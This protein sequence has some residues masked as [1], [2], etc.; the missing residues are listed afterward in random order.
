M[1]QP[2]TSGGSAPGNNGHAVVPNV[3]GAPAAYHPALPNFPV[4][5]GLNSFA[6]SLNG[7]SQMPPQTPGLQAS[8][9][10]SFF[11][12]IPRPHSSGNSD[13]ERLER[14]KREILEGQNPIYKAVPQPNFLESIYL[15]RTLQAQN[16][17]PAHPEQVAIGENASTGPQSSAR[18]NGDVKTSDF[19]HSVLVNQ[20]RE[21]GDAAPVRTTPLQPA[22]S[23]VSSSSIVSSG[24]PDSTN[25]GRSSSMPQITSKSN[26][27]DQR[28]SYLSQIPTQDTPKFSPT[29]GNLDLPKRSL[30]Y[31][32]RQQASQPPSEKLSMLSMPENHAR[33]PMSSNTSVSSKDPPYDPKEGL[34]RPGD[35]AYGL[36]DRSRRVAD[37]R[38]SRAY[39]SRYVRNGDRDRER[40]RDKEL[41]GEHDRRFDYRSDDR[42]VSVEDYRVARVSSEV[43]IDRDQHS[44]KGLSH[45]DN[46]HLDNR[47]DADVNRS[48]PSVSGRSVRLADD[49]IP[50]PV[51]PGERLT[52]PSDDNSPIKHTT[53]NDKA[54][55]VSS[56][57]TSVNTD[58]SQS[59][60]D[61]NRLPRAS[62]SVSHARFPVDERS[63]PLDDRARLL[64]VDD[65]ERH[66]AGGDRSHQ[67]SQT[68][69]R[70][71][72]AS[73]L[74]ERIGGR[75]PPP[76][77]DRIGIRIPLEERITS[78]PL[79]RL[80]RPASALQERISDRP[81][82][83][84]RIGSRP[85]AADSRSLALGDIGDT[86]SVLTQSA[87]T[88]FRTVDEKTASLPLSATTNTRTL[89]QRVEDRHSRP[90]A[91]DVA[92]FQSRP[93]SYGIDTRA[94]TRDGP[95]PHPSASESFLKERY[96]GAPEQNLISAAAYR[97]DPDRHYTDTRRPDIEPAKHYERPI[98]RER[99]PTADHDHA[100]PNLETREWRERASYPPRT[101]VATRPE[102]YTGE[103]YTQ[104]PPS[105]SRDWAQNDRGYR[106]PEPAYDA[107]RPSPPIVDAE[108]DRY[109]DR[110][111][112]RRASLAPRSWDR[113][114]ALTHTRP[115]PEVYPP[116][117][118]VDV[119]RERYPP[120]DFREP[121]RVR[122]RSPSPHRRSAGDSLDEL[123]PTKRVREE[124][125]Y[126]DPPRPLPY[127]QPEH[128]AHSRAPSPPPSTAGSYYDTRAAYPPR[129]A[130]DAYSERERAPDLGYYERRPADMGPPRPSPY[131]GRAV[132]SRPDLDREGNRYSLPPP[133]TA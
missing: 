94:N 122:Q 106:L 4:F 100:K 59:A 12:Q 114:D 121:S 51:V 25:L 49:R 76:L 35:G 64:P 81:P 40:D 31:H 47:A 112:G 19:A 38:D 119:E 28:F 11:P 36:D 57:A 23:P 5:P 61:D 10:Q 80:T 72:A 73:A 111:L 87:S 79:D 78:P 74:E 48:A 88:R 77:E 67:T 21:N 6:Q 9:Q 82:L 126:Y 130:H 3:N 30:T 98:L 91:G 32:S 16:S 17:V 2:F 54:H 24:R 71:P 103:R 7:Q 102:S 37:T 85:G 132:Y 15:G 113:E 125:T 34:R 60:V 127:A 110:D 115:P 84:E 18:S 69:E 116:E 101:S 90:P 20:S 39:D 117:D 96:R 118:R 50:R 53:E 97:N 123:R 55:F 108:R 22:Q 70:N 65:R 83:E 107:H 1:S 95:S 66:L 27:A 62:A 58:K 33:H 8:T 105:D 86:R 120:A 89:Q 13:L 129:D 93:S 124:S 41:E 99:D 133:R 14:L 52:Q 75:A 68:S 131:T 128:Y 46:R 104:P 63:R 26:Q 43:S 42:R 45:Q 56:L 109:L 29:H 92:P 44:Q